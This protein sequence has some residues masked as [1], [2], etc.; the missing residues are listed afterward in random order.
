MG[1]YRDGKL[2]FHQIIFKNGSI[3]CLQIV[4]DK[5][6][7]GGFYKTA[8]GTS[9]IRGD[10][11][12]KII[13]SRTLNVLR[14]FNLGHSGPSNPVPSRAQSA[15]RP[16]ITSTSGR[17]STASSIN[18]SRS[19][20][21]KN[22]TTARPRTPPPPSHA[23]GYVS[24]KDDKFSL[25]Y[26]DKKVLVNPSEEETGSNAITSINVVV[27]HGRGGSGSTYIVASLGSGRVVKLDVGNILS[28]NVA[29][30]PEYLVND[31]MW[32]HTGP[33][34]GLTGQSENGPSV[35][36]TT[37]DDRQL[38]VWDINAMAPLA[39]NTLKTV[40]RSCHLDNTSQ[41]VIV[42]STSG[43]ITIFYIALSVYNKNP[44]V[45]NYLLNKLDTLPEVAFRKDSQV[46][47]TCLKFS[48]S[49]QRIAA[50]SRDDSIYI[51]TFRHET[52][53]ANS[54]PKVTLTALHKL[55]GHSSTICHFDWTIDSKR[56]YS[57]S[58][59]YETLVWDPESGRRSAQQSS[60]PALATHTCPSSLT[61][62]AW[63]PYT[64]GSDINTFDVNVNKKL[65]L[66]SMDQ[67]GF[68]RLLSWPCVVKNS[69]ARCY[70]GH[71]SHCQ[72][73]RFF[74]E[75]QWVGSIG[76]NDG[77][78]VIWEVKPIITNSDSFR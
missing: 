68:V 17:P 52:P 15:S 75:G 7:V 73:A 14:D 69:P 27:G 59:A 74:N 61:L 11:V 43:T 18:S 76:G 60:D 54:V 20:S 4:S 45:R 10:R 9:N 44:R 49:N 78:V 48:P 36:I 3:N 32:F 62:G 23:A 33:V 35:M 5:I 47:I 51:Y 71:S 22:I 58:Q 25:N 56:L 37:G 40:S 63:P 72:A 70:P 39:R 31:L 2:N 29:A 13:D 66:T 28:D 53:S 34:Y 67:G 64:H 30:K 50:G 41:F 8:P 38:F 65:L 16:R 42:G 6:I 12:I 77:S 57:S 55:K 19:S 1:S 46:E 26:E 24:K 21:S